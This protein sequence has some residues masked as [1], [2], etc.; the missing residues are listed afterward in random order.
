[1]TGTHRAEDAGEGCGSALSEREG[2]A[3][4]FT[5]VDAGFGIRRTGD[6]CRLGEDREDAGPDFECVDRAPVLAAAVAAGP[7]S[8]IVGC[9]SGLVGRGPAAG[10]S[11]CAATRD[12]GE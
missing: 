11:S 12:I 6:S 4:R 5:G 8:R 10:N 2:P 3:D 7:G 1:R 9:R